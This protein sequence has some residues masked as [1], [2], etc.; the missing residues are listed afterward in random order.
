MIQ[1]LEWDSQFFGFPVGQFTVH[2]FTAGAELEEQL[3]I[4]RDRGFRCLYS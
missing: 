3:R 4:A 2:R 1:S